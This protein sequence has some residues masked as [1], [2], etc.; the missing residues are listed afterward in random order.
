M[1]HWGRTIVVDSVGIRLG[2]LILPWGSIDGLA[3]A[4]GITVKEARALTEAEGHAWVANSNVPYRPLAY[5]RT[6]FAAH[7][8]SYK[9]AAA[10]LARIATAAPQSRHQ[11]PIVSADSTALPRTRQVALAGC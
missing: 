8:D 3:N 2:R 1:Y 6:V 10:K 11:R 4:C 7:R 5:L 9:I